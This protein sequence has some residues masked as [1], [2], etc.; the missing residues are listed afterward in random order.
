MISPEA[1]LLD[2]KQDLKRERESKVTL[3]LPDLL[4]PLPAR[5]SRMGQISS[6]LLPNPIDRDLA[7]LLNQS[8]P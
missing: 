6:T 3:D 5:N 8:N 1:P 7:L 2:A 4:P